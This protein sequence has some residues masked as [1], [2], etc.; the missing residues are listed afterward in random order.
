MLTSGTRHSRSGFAD[1]AEGRCRPKPKASKNGQ[2]NQIHLI[3]RIDLFTLRLFVS[4]VEEGQIGRAA[5]RENIAPSTA[6]K[7]IQDL[8][9]IAGIELLDRSAK[10]VVPSA[11]GAV[12]LRHARDI[13]GS[14][15]ALRAEIAAFND[16]REG[17]V[18][19]A[20]ARSIIDPFLTG[21]LSGF[22]RDFPLVELDVHEVENGEIVEM[23]GRGDADIGVFA[24]EARLDLEGLHIL[25]FREDR[26]VVIVP[27]SHPLSRRGSIG[28]GELMSENIVALKA[29]TGAF[30]AAAKRAGVRFDPR[31]SVKS[32]SLAVNLVC[33]G[34]GVA[35]L[36]E[37]MLS[38]EHSEN[39]SS[40][41]LDETWA[42]RVIQIAVARNRPLNPVADHFLSRLT[43]IS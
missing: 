3:R 37:G 20:S 12:V 6:T 41:G 27:K 25:P 30:A 7:R 39:V 36:P 15:E 42:R 21:E 4:V 18:T 32:P 9:A 17:K 28:F 8:E 23:V 16:G 11:A 1:I 10:G 43:A 35:I 34:F 29:L 14:I 31:V 13:V 5:A 22:A 40:V 2:F 38:R 24:Q 33:D 26:L 19:I